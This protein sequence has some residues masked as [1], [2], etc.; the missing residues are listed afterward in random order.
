MDYPDLSPPAAIEL[1]RL[2]GTRNLTPWRSET[3]GPDGERLRVFEHSS[4]TPLIIEDPVPVSRLGAELAWRVAFDVIALKVTVRGKLAA[5]LRPI[6]IGEA[7]HPKRGELLRCDHRD[8]PEQRDAAID[9]MLLGRRTQAIM[10]HSDMLLAM[11]G[12]LSPTGAEPLMAAA[13]AELDLLRRLR[14]SR[15]SPEELLLILD[16]WDRHQRRLAR[17]MAGHPELPV[18]RLISQAEDG[19]LRELRRASGITRGELQL[20]LESREQPQVRSV[21]PI[22][23]NEEGSSTTTAMPFSCM[24]PAE[25]GKARRS[26]ITSRFTMQPVGSSL[27]REQADRAGGHTRLVRA[28]ARRMLGSLGQRVLSFEELE[29]VGNEALAQAAKRYDPTR[30][31]SFTTFAYRRVQGAMIDAVRR[32]TAGRRSYM[33]AED[34]LATTQRLLSRAAEGSSAGEYRTLERRV[35]I[36]REGVGRTSVALRLCESEGCASFEG[37]AA[38]EPSPE[39][40]LERMDVRHRLRALVA[41]LEPQERALIDALYVHDRQMSEFAEEIGT[42]CATISRRHAQ[43]IARLRK[44]L[45]AQ[46]RGRVGPGMCASRADR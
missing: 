18:L 34:R 38:D 13:E 44:R 31:A 35:Q 25:S 30:A 41:D 32:W 21:R 45:L 39:Q 1:K 8:F 11:I 12:P 33:R 7:D 6:V 16:A 29:S 4:T 3:T 27:T 15:I 10:Q 46:D 2:W 9:E 14:S 40:V 24:R 22:T 26:D 43:L 28:I 37:V 20:L 19:M 23:E 5:F 36:A 17:G 42:S